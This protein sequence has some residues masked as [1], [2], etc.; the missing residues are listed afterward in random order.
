[1]G[2][3][4]QSKVV[5][6]RW[7][8][9]GPP[10]ARAT[11]G[12][13]TLQLLFIL[14]PVLFGLIG[15]AIDLG[16]LYLSK[17]ELKAAANAMA[18]ASAQR[19]IGT[20]QAISDATAAGQLTLDNSTGFGNKYLFG[21][22][23]IGQTNGAL[24]SNVPQ[25]AY[26]T[27]LQDALSSDGSGG[28][29]DSTSRHVLVTLNADVP[30]TFWGFL[31][32]ATDRRVSVAARAVAGIS[33]P[34][35]TACS[36]EAFAVA[37]IDPTDPVDFGF[38]PDTKY[39]LGYSCSGTP[40][41]FGLPGA[42]RRIP[43][44]I[45]NRLDTNA[46]IF[47]DENSQLFRIA[48]QGMPGS[49]NSALSCFSV[50][51]T[52]VVWTDAAPIA[53]SSTP[54]SIPNVVQAS[55]CGLTTRFEPTPPGVCSAIPDVETLSSIYTPDTDNTDIDTYASYTGNGRRVVTVSIVDALN[56]NGMT[57]LG[58]RQFLV[59]PDLNF[60]DVNAADQN[61]RFRALY[62]GSVVPIKQGRF[63]GCQISNGPGKVVL[64]Q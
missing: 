31:P 5:A 32:L 9:V 46:T 16:Q 40:A 48:A 58:F 18:L 34:L 33:A 1:M 2:I 54:N 25:P 35:C 53:C 43:Y 8:A 17:G 11:R 22:L 12:A 37:A 51:A 55:M 62:I 45:V 30:L 4:N 50:N 20:D 21:S 44:L 28:G 56:P 61:G 26:F 41:P 7:W 59:D 47:A 49:T 42:F 23:V 63:D 38:V 29:G 57:I 14:V 64:H 15:F 13:A 36:M 39:T 6:G 60:I 27:T 19:L 24:T 52:E 3:R 10:C